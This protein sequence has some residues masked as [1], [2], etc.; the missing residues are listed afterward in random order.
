MKEKAIV[1][2]L[3]FKNLSREFP[4][5]PVF[6]TSPAGGGGCFPGSSVGKDLPA[7]QEILVRFLGWEDPL[8]KG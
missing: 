6:S 5:G 7:M 2:Q 3:Y 4:G 8:E 1:Y